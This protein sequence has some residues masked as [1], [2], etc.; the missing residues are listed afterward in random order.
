MFIVNFLFV[1]G[2]TYQPQRIAFEHPH[3]RTLQSSFKHIDGPAATSSKEADPTHLE[4]VN[5]WMLHPR[6]DSKTESGETLLNSAER[7][8]IIAEGQDDRVDSVSV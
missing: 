7:L 2:G 1:E 8:Q 6:F 4:G 3:Q 5:A